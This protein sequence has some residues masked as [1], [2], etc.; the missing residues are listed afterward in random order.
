MGHL[1]DDGEIMGDVDRR[2]IELLDDIAHGG[3]HFHL[4][5]HVKSGRRLVEDDEIGP[6]RH[7]HG[8]HG[9]LELAARNLVRVAVA[10]LV[11]VGKLQ[12]A[13]KI[14]GVGLGLLARHHAVVDGGFDGLLHQLMGRIEG[15][16]GRLRHIGDARAPERTL[17]GLGGR[18]E[19]NSVEDNGPL[20]DAAAGPGKAH[21]GES[22][23]RLASARFAD[24]AQ[25]LAPAQR[26]IDALDDRM[27][28][29]IGVALDLEALDVDQNLAL[30]A[31]PLSAHRAIRLSREAASR[32]RS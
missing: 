14:A 21:G 4:R 6:A 11:G 2:R 3:E 22:E 15:G 23:G 27:P 31:F 10:D 29:A 9:A 24:E 32:P 25:N 30:N 16:G 7:G 26:Q 13:I 12:T 17:L 1:G 28:D 20:D 19:V 8:G 18:P 5:R